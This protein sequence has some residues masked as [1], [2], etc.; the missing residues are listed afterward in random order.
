MSDMHGRGWRG[1]PDFQLAALSLSPETVAS[2]PP[3]WVIA[4]GRGSS[5]LARIAAP[6][7]ACLRLSHA[8]DDRNVD[9]LAGVLAGVNESDSP[10]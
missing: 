2:S 6:S 1:S 10:R 8:T 7:A 4:E 3:V 5:R 9:F